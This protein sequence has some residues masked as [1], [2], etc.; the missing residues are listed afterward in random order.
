MKKNICLANVIAFIILLGCTKPDTNH[1]PVA[2]IGNV[3]NIALDREINFEGTFLSDKKYLSVPTDGLFLPEGQEWSKESL[4][5][6][7]TNQ[8]FVFYFGANYPISSFLVQ[9]DNNDI[10]Q[11]SYHNYN[12]PIE[13]WQPI[14]KVP[15]I[16][17][18]G[19]MTREGYFLSI[20]IN[21]DAIKFQALEESDD[22]LFSIGELQV[23]R[24]QVKVGDTFQ[25]DGYNSSDQDNDILTFAWSIIS[26]PDNSTATLSDSLIINPT[27]IPDVEGEYTLQLI[28]NDGTESS[29]QDIV[30][31]NIE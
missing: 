22:D 17:G 31:I 26:I 23:N 18:W 5:W 20:P 21:A 28:V 10:Y 7:G 30:V 8:Y 3:T 12:D 4:N 27:F 16:E 1:K 14:Y 6:E 9:A 25:L 2:V 11:V 15:K 24:K 13:T 29:D 19:L